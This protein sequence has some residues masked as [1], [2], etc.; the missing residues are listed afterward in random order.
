M[1]A[2]KTLAFPSHQ[3]IRTV[4]KPFHGY[5]IPL[6]GKPVTGSH[7]VIWD[8]PECGRQ[9]SEVG[10]HPNDLA[11]EIKQDA[12]CHYCRGQKRK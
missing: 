7:E 5:R 12:R 3:Y 10:D 2:E 1:N 8:C 11:A 4:I 9:C 6:R